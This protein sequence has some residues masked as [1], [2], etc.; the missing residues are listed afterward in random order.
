[1][2]NLSTETLIQI[3]EFVKGKNI[4]RAQNTELITKISNDIDEVVKKDLQEFWSNISSQE[5][6]KAK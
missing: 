1:M 5:T 6:L 3:A 4:T 2:K